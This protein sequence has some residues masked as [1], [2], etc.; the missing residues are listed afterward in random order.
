[1]SLTAAKYKLKQTTNHNTYQTP[2]WKL[3][4][5]YTV[6]STGLYWPCCSA[7]VLSLYSVST[8][9]ARPGASCLHR[10]CEQMHEGCFS[11]LHGSGHSIYAKPNTV[12]CL[13]SLGSVLG[14]RWERI[15][16]LVDRVQSKTNNS[17]HLFFAYCMSDSG[18]RFLMIWDH[19]ISTQSSLV[20]SATNPISQ[21]R[22]HWLVCNRH[23][24]CCIDP[25]G[26]PSFCFYFIL[27]RQ[28]IAL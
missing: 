3:G 19:F 23:I 10:S 2:L 25:A 6:C 12:G 1:M 5:E 20:Y 13:D 16:C 15:W 24:L 28:D 11:L 7:V 22:E 8:L 17:K 26:M 4:P 14:C 27:L 18:F 21:M 9:S